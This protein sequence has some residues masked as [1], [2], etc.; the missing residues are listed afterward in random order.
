MSELICPKCGSGMRSRDDST[1]TCL[2]CAGIWI[3]RATYADSLAEAGGTDALLSEL[4]RV[5]SPSGH[6]CPTCK[7]NH[8]EV[9]LARGIELDWCRTCGGIYFDMGEFERLKRGQNRP[10]AARSARTQSQETRNGPSGWGLAGTAADW[11]VT[12]LLI[13]AVGV[14][15]DVVMD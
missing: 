11:V 10:G 13:G 15:V 6:P 14:V 12:D 2:G 5:Y 9:S 4:D 7:T 3:S 1:A 8:L